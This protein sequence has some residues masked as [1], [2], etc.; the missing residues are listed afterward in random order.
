MN[1]HSDLAGN[2]DEPDAVA[3]HI[4]SHV[5]QCFYEVTFSR[6]VNTCLVYVQTIC[7]T[8]DKA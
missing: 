6:L 1:R 7:I 4:A 2:H 5:T 3:S 8:S